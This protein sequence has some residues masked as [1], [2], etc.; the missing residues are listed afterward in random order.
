M[1]WGSLNLLATVGAA[2][3]GAS[4]LLFI[5]NLWRSRSH[6]AIAPAD[7]WGGGTL[8]WIWPFLSAVATTVL[9]IASIFTPWAVVW[10]AVPVAAAVTIWFW[11]RRGE[12]MRH[13][14]L[15]QSP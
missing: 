4:V 1:G 6:G 8:E 13:I 7:P 10:G 14:S 9:F 5:I 15:E 2:V 11:P 12:T 3:I